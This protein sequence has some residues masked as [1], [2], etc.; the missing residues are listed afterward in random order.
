MGFEGILDRL[1]AIYIPSISIYKGR[2]TNFDRFWV[3]M[4][5]PL[6][7]DWLATYLN[8]KLP[9]LWGDPPFLGRNYPPLGRNYPPLGAKLRFS[10]GVVF[11]WLGKMTGFFGPEKFRLGSENDLKS[12]NSMVKMDLKNSSWAGKPWFYHEKRVKKKFAAFGGEFFLD[13]K[14]SDWDLKMDLKSSD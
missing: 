10:L 9:P 5:R 1:E 12:S 13:L 8:A 2:N 14:S 11:F 6:S 3:T 7:P 4:C